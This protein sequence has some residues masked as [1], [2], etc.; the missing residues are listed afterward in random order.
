MAATTLENVALF[1]YQKAD[2]KDSRELTISKLQTLVYYAFGIYCSI[3]EEVL[4]EG[5]F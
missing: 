3:F 1:F 2:Q 4:F 5:K